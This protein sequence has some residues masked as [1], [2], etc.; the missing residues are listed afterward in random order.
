MFVAISWYVFACNFA[1]AQRSFAARAMS[2]RQ[3]GCAEENLA[4]CARWSD[5]HHLATA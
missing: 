4:R 2:Y 5:C 3:F 1:K